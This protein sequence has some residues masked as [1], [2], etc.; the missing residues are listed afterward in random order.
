MKK[1]LLTLATLCFTSTTVLFAQDRTVRGTVLDDKGQPLEAAYI[2]VVGDDDY[3]TY[4]DENG[5][6]E[7]TVPSNA[8]FIEINY[9]PYEIKKIEISDENVTSTL[10]MAELLDKDIVINTYGGEI[11][12]K[13]FVGTA[14]IIGEKQIQKRVIS[15]VTNA[16]EG[17]VSGVLVSNPS[18]QPGSAA[19]IRIRGFA[20][21]NGNSN[22]LYVVDGAIYMGDIA[23]INTADIA[24]VSILKDATATSQ[25]G[26][27]GSNGVVVITTKSGKANAKPRI[28]VDA[29]VGMTNRAIRNYDIVQDQGEYLKFAWDA[30]RNTSLAGARN[31]SQGRIDAA[32]RDAT[33][34]LSEALGYYPNRAYGVADSF[35]LVLS[36]GTLNPALGAPLYSDNWDDEVQRTGLRQEYNVSAAGASKEKNSDY[37]LSLG[38]LNE[39]GYV[40]RSDYERISARLNVN[41]KLKDWLKVGMNLSGSIQNSNELESI[42][43]TAG[44]YNPFFISRAMAPVFPVYYYNGNG[45]REYDPL[46]GD[47]KY[48][49]GSLSTANE[50]SIGTRT[51]GLLPNSNVLGT[52]NLNQNK[53]RQFAFIANPY[54]E[55]DLSKIAKGL[56]FRTDVN[57]NFVSGY[58]NNF[59]NTLYGDSKLYGGSVSV[60]S[61][62]ANIYTWK[63][64]LTY[65]LLFLKEHSLS[66]LAAHEVYGLVSKSL[67][68][69]RRGLPTTNFYDMTGAAV[70]VSSSSY[71]DEDKMESF[72]AAV[73][74]NYGGKYFFEV[75]ARR[76]GTSRFAEQ[77]RWG[78]FWSV[79]GSWALSEEDFMKNSNSKFIKGFN[80]LKIKSSYGTQGNNGNNYY[81]YLGL[82]ATDNPNGS[83]PG[84]LVS[85]IANP[86]LKWESQA[87]FNIG[88]DFNYKNRLRGELA[89]YA[90]ENADQL[91]SRPFAL[92]SG[93][94]SRLEN[95]MTSVNSGLE[96]GLD[97]SVVQPTSS[98][99]NGFVWNVNFT[100]ATL[101]NKI[102]KMPDGEGQDTLVLTNMVRVEGYS[103]YTYYLVKS[104]GLDADGNE[105]FEYQAADG[106]RKDTTDYSYAVANG[107]RQLMGSSY[108]RFSGGLTNTFSYKG[109]DLSFMFTF[110]LGGKYYDGGYQELMG[111][112]QRIGGNIHQD[113]LTDRWTYE[114]REG[115]LPRAENDNVNI[116]NSTDRWLISRNYLNFRNVNL[117]Y[118]FSPRVLE[119]IGVSSLRLYL[120][121]DNVWLFTKRKGMDPQYSISGN[122]SGAGAYNYPATRAF[123]F[124]INLGL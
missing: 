94:A 4:T 3:S 102:T 68:A 74:Y 55:A 87:M 44:G 73:R 86:D 124:G 70:A 53:S 51:G 21:I 50:S 103:M 46:T 79:G 40:K 104:K 75:N 67:S 26:S 112:G 100:G 85:Q 64:V 72:L 120:A 48:D 27:R 1:T 8:N 82:M 15:N 17:N 88:I 80:E 28:N 117:G 99:P 14:G 19:A 105:L 93:V 18:G 35:K 81:G 22:P 95:V 23:S 98:N 118:T 16:I 57:Y 71:T 36:D 108:D 78:N 97:Y 59:R 54:L 32:G 42:N 5:N 121:C 39:K 69:S 52:M 2:G 119:N 113:W 7:L 30:L 60:G 77:N 33:N 62:F 11:T 37:Y 56:K 123:T 96:I 65:D 84:A 115:T 58:S 47:Y 45:E 76:D 24:N 116:S 31:P 89:Y 38:Y 107:G 25:Y 111:N 106:T 41:S 6:Y 101:N 109:F 92:S 20:S 114:N 90:K 12:K 34:S 13:Q 9:Q 10:S 49:W 91:Y 43:S 110:G 29:R 66:V 122:V 83:Y 61:S 63:Q